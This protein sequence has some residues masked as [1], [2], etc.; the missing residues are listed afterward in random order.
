MNNKDLIETIKKNSLIGNDE[1]IH[2]RDLLN[3]KID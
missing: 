1:V 3:Y 2:L